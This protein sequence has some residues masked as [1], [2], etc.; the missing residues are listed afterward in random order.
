MNLQCLPKLQLCIGRR[1]LLP[2]LLLAHFQD[3]A[4]TSCRSSHDLGTFRWDTVRMTCFS[5]VVRQ[6]RTQLQHKTKQNMTTTHLHFTQRKRLI[7]ELS[8]FHISLSLVLIKSINSLDICATRHKVLC[9]K[10]YVLS[11]FAPVAAAVNVFGFGTI[12]SLE[13]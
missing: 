8:V 2:L 6:R 12:V 11:L 13:G 1:W 9:M 5:G 7:F 10:C 4:D 3:S